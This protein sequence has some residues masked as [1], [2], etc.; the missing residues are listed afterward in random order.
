MKG[1]PSPQEARTLLCVI[2]NGPIHG[3]DVARKVSIPRGSV[4]VLLARLIDKGLIF[5][6][7]EIKPTDGYLGITRRFYWPSTIGYAFK[8]A[9]EALNSS[10][11]SAASKS[12]SSSS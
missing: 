12:E 10:N 11:E 9:L 7:L 8:P 1:W 6:D 2:Q 4:Y 5:S 3:L